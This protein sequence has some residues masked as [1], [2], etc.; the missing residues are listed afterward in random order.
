MTRSR[1]GAEAANWRQGWY[2]NYTEKE[3]ENRL[4]D[5]QVCGG[6]T[7]GIKQKL[8]ESRIRKVKCDET[9]PL[10][11]RCF[12]TGR[13][14]DG[15][16]V[17][18]GGGSPHGRHPKQ[19]G[20]RFGVLSPWK[21]A[22]ALVSAA[23]QDEKLRFEWFL[24]RTVKKIPGIF[25]LD[26][27]EMLLLPASFSEP[28]VLH[29][30]LSVS[31]IHQIGT[32][33]VEQVATKGLAHNINEKLVL[34]HYIKATHELRRSS[35]DKQSIRIL[36]ITCLLFA[37]LE[38]LRGRFRTAKGHIFAGLKILQEKQ[39]HLNSSGK[40]NDHVQLTPGSEEAA[41][42]WIAAAFSRL[43]VQVQLSSEVRSPSE[44]FVLISPLD[45]PSQFT[46]INEAW[47]QL[48]RIFCDI[49]FLTRQ[50]HLLPSE[51]SRNPT[52][53]DCR[54]G[55][56]LDLAWWER[57]FERSNV[58]HRDEARKAVATP[59]LYA[60]HAMATIMAHTCLSNTET[61][62]D[63]YTELFLEILAFSSSIWIARTPTALTDNMLN[64]SRSIVDIGWL[65]LLYYTAIKCRIHRIRLHAIRLLEST[66]HREG[67]WDARITAAVAR[68]V[69]RIEE[70]GF[71][72]VMDGDEC[73]ALHEIPATETLSRVSLPSHMRVL[74]LQVV[75]PDEPGEHV[76]LRYAQ[77]GT[78]GECVITL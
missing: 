18:G 75:L 53:L 29:A 11:N 56:Q 66:S 39:R 57:T 20:T 7:R 12:S 61:V 17:W 9:Y 24:D 8:I 64:M 2:S 46:S 65:P 42:D 52:L 38:L 71:N 1:Y 14:C 25:T 49:I 54:D 33:E 22:S 59:V 58:Y 68:N 34:Q 70:S 67:I 30:V 26:F 41:D 50:H 73:F 72:G 43:Y 77:G 27:F 10:C 78:P 15:Y 48:E 28:A 76:L 36:L 23:G 60:Y 62:Y 16:G 31:C 32:Y 44:V 35:D 55:V 21:P 4:Q 37:Y 5:L 40:E 13:T 74:A 19:P 51:D 3:C 47:R 45:R 69:M 63:D 6:L